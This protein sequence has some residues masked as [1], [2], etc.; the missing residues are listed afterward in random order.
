MHFTATSD[1]DVFVFPFGVL[2]FNYNN[3]IDCYTLV[4]LSDIFMR[5]LK[6]P[7]LVCLCILTNSSSWSSTHYRYTSLLI[8][9]WMRT[10]H[11]GN[12]CKSMQKQVHGKCTYFTSLRTDIPNIS[13]YKY[14]STNVMDFHDGASNTSMQYLRNIISF[15][16]LCF[17]NLGLKMV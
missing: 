15:H 6:V 7:S 17:S 2:S 1:V 5:I 13:I 8:K 3:N 11:R 14:I 10:D 12:M 4:W 9:I 16:S